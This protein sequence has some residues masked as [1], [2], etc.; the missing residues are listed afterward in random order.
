[1]TWLHAGSTIYDHQ[2]E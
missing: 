1:L 2:G